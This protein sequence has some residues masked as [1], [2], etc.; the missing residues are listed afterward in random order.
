[1]REL[2]WQKLRIY[3]VNVLLNTNVKEQELDRYDFVVV[4]TYAGNNAF[5]SKFPHAK[6]Q[7]QFELCE[8]PVLRLSTKFADKSIMVLDGPFM[9]INPFGRTGHFVMGH[10][11]HAIHHR[12]IGEYPKIPHQ[13]KSLLNR[14]VIK[15]P[16]V[17]HIKKMFA[18]AENFFPGIK[19]GASHIGSMFTIRTVPP[20]HEHDDVRPT[21]VEQINDR[22]VLVFSGKI[23]TCADAAE[24]I[25]QLVQ[26]GSAS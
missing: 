18:A 2:C 20:Y 16:P 9:N 8:K 17:T 22:L 24:Q 25:R 5:L 12:N 23:V 7:Y 13:F 4:A 10:V 6:K 11:E 26:R 1:L 14:G 3:N 15:N 19:K 21:L